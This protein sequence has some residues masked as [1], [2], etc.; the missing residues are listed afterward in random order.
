MKLVNGMTILMA[1]S[2]LMLGCS[3]NHE[4]KKMKGETT[5]VTEAGSMKNLDETIASW[6]ERPKLA[7]KEMLG[8]YGPPQEVSVERII[9]NNQGPYKRIMVTREEIPHDF[10]MPHMDFLEHTVL[11]DVP[12]DRAD[13]LQ[14]FDGSVSFY[15]TG[16]ELSARCDLEGHNILTLNLARDIIEGKTTAQEARVSFG[17]YVKQDM[18]G[19]KPAYVETLQFRPHSMMKAAFADTKVLPGAPN[20]ETAATG[21]V[22]PDAEVLGFVMATNTNEIL[23]AAQAQKKDVSKPVMTYAKMLQTEH[24]KNSAKAMKLSQSSGVVPI[25]TEEVDQLKQDGA[26]NL[27]AITPLQGK[28]FEVAYLTAMVDDHKKVISMIDDQL[29]P[30]AKNAQVKAHLKETRDHVAMHLDQAQDLKRNL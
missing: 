30:M 9:W 5:S 21:E 8:K 14:K 26:K 10:P 18:M 2:S 23:A 11:Y 27:A 16:G 15:R 22:K 4:S 29:L 3:S 6:P 17:E 28:E 7:V 19:K 25:D 12:A 20:R 1:A 24:A 13:E